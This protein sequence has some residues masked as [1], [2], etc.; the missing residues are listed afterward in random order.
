MYQHSIV[1]RKKAAFTAK[2]KGKVSKPRDSEK[3]K[4]LE[5]SIVL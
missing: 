5:N 4:R 1:E 3:D 2:K